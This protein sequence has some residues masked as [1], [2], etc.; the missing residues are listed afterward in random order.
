MVIN[1]WT[2]IL[3]V[4]QAKANQLKF[5]YILADSWFASVE[6][7]KFIEEKKKYVIFDMKS[8]RSAILVSQSSGKP[9]TK[10]QWT[11]ISQLDI[12]DNTPVQV[13]LKDLDFPVLLVKQVFKDEDGD[14]QG[15][16][17]FWSTTTW[18]YPIVTL[19]Q[20]TKNGRA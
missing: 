16:V 5:K 6:N 9:T 14:I 11:S 20:S 4:K 7:M 15:R 19:L 1:L 10:S 17:D 13:W 8:N 2:K 12:P 3:L 18:A